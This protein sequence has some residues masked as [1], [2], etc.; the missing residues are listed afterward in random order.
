MTASLTGDIAALR[1][2][3]KTM[4]LVT[5]GRFAGGM[6]G[7]VVSGTNL[8]DSLTQRGKVIGKCHVA[9]C[10]WEPFLSGNFFQ[11]CISH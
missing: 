6:I 8:V 10:M 9:Q 2:Y 5:D 1:A 3:T 7:R 4:V 11:C